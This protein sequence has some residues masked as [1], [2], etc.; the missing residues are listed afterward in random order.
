MIPVLEVANGL[1]GA[2]RLAWLDASGMRYFNRTV[3]G[4]WRSFF[5]A[6][7]VAPLL[8]VLLGLRFAGGE[9][10]APFWRFASIELISY[11]VLWVA[12]PVIM[13]GVTQAMDRTANY[14][15]YIVA[16]NWASV[17]QNVLFLPFAIMVELELFGGLLRN[18]LWVALMIIVLAYIFVVTRTALQVGAAAAAILV[19]ID[20]V[21][22]VFVNGFAESLIRVG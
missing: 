19:V 13:L 7:L 17:W 15:P 9:I 4:F 22:S 5:A 14:I 3:E 16:Y 1:Y 6:V 11:V 18:G 21:I 20:L 8:A 12:F 10:G 2:W